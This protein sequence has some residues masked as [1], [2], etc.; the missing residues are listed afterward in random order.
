MQ[1]R[2]TSLADYLSRDSNGLALSSFTCPY[3][4]RDHSVPFGPMRTGQNLVAEIPT[5]A[6][7][8]LGHAPRKSQV[9]YDRAI[10]EIIQASVIQPLTASGMALSGLPLG[11]VGHLLD[12]ELPMGDEA[13]ALVDP[14]VELLIGAGS[15]VI[16]DLTKWIAT[17]TH[18]PYILVGT[19]PSMN[20]YTSITATITENDVKTSRMLTPANAVLLDVDIQVDAPMTMIHAGMGDLAARAIC[21]ADWKLSQ[22]IHGT[23]FCPLPFEMTAENERMFLGAAARI[24]QREPAAIELLS[25]AIL[26]SGLSMTVLEGETSPS[27]GGE[28]IISHFW[29]LLT[30]TRALPKN[31]HGTQVGVGT[32]I[33]IAFY[34]YVRNV[35]PSRIDPREVIRRR[36]PMETLLEENTSR[37]GQAGPLFNEVVHSKYL[38]DEALVERIRWIQDHWEHIWAEIDPYL[39]S[40]DQV[41]AP[42]RLA[43]MPLTLASVQRSKED[44]IE[45]LVKGPQYRTRYTLLDLAWE[46]GLMPDA[47]EEVLELADV[48]KG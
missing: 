41:R 44:A 15:G 3:C 2:I 28:H 42:L 45:A 7:S 23:Y 46:L 14:N 16:A 27:S 19:A 40:I 25:E 11:Q 13:C 10:E 17:Y 24:A 5:V 35:D 38:S 48:L 20:A 18:L 30:H 22:L 4:G 39:P 9:V 8:V 33:M 21:N 31:L 36:A 6:A 32:V 1:N 37:Y 43:G 26:K 29:D 12:S 47:A 34:Q